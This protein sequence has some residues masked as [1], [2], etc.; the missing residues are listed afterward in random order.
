M[1]DNLR[2]QIYRNQNQKETEELVAIW[3]ANNRYEW[4]DLTFEIIEEILRSR[5]DTLPPQN[6]PIYKLVKYEPEEVFENADMEA[7]LKAEDAPIF[8][9]PRQVLRFEK[10]LNRVAIVAVVATGVVTLLG[11]PEIHQ[12]I[13]S[14]FPQNVIWRAG[15]WF[16][17][18]WLMSFL[19]G[20][21]CLLLYFSL[22]S[23]SVILKILM[24]MEYNSRK[25]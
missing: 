21:Q 13:A 17:I 15:V 16:I 12:T 14:I 23:L 24:E 20:I 9:D 4:T 3:Q 10:W 5:L 7:F 2:M 6:E 1:P 8:Y 11:M 25:A 19:V 18:V 22:R